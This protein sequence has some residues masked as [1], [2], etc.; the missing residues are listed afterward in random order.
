MRCK[1][2]DGVIYVI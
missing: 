2:N 1:A